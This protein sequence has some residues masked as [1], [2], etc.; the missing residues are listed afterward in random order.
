MIDKIKHTKNR[1][2]L[3]FP[4]DDGSVVFDGATCRRAVCRKT[5]ERVYKVTCNDGVFRQL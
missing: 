3:A 5:Q 2:Q 4:G 1:D